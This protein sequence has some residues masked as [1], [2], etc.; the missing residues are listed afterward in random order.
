M[1]NKGLQK[2][3]HLKTGA[4]L[5]VVGRVLDHASNGVCMNIDILLRIRVT[6]YTG[7][8]GT[9]VGY[10]SANTRTYNAILFAKRQ[11]YV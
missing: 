5:F 4:K 3:N 8:N 2:F 1:Q 11:M 9:K 7:M 10:N 6:K